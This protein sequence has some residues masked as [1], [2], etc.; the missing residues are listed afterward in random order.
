MNELL[1]LRIPA[2]ISARSSMLAIVLLASTFAA[3]STPQGS[4][5]KT[6]QVSGPVDL[7]VQTRSGNITVR[8]GP[9]GSVAIRGKS[10]VGDRWLAGNRHAEV[11]EIEQHPPLRQ[12]GNSIRIDYVNARDI[13]VDYEITVPAETAVR[14]HT[15]S[16]DQT[17]EGVHGNADLQSG[18][19][20]MRL[21]RLT[22]EIRVQT[23]SGDVRAREIAGPVRGGAGSGNLEV[24]ETGAGDIDL[25]TGSGNIAVRGIQGAFRGEAGSG[26]VTAEGTQMGAWEVRTGSG[27]IRVRLPASAAF[28]ANLSTSSGTLDIDAPITMTVQGRV[29]E[30]HK[31]IVGKVRGG[32]PLLTLHTGSGDIHIE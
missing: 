11:A 2:S 5:E 22:G 21:S 3:A 4:F 14:A 25:H 19:G 10:F 18:S 13:S 24:E 32:G 31:Q 26:D 8:S 17:I 7:E 28:D 9:A 27:T 16:G 1:I 23:G 30:S 29:Q 6:F 15:G 12:D 20:D